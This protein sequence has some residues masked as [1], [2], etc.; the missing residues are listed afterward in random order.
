[1]ARYPRHESWRDVSDETGFN[2]HWHAKN[3]ETE[4]LSIRMANEAVEP[5]SG[6]ISGWTVEMYPHPESE[7]MERW[8]FDGAH[9]AAE[10]VS[11]LMEKWA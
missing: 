9:E 11:E 6:Y 7:R 2:H 1:M 3:S 8:C 10:K 4:Y 5:L